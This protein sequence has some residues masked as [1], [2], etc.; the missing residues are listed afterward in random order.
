[1]MPL[2]LISWH[3]WPSVGLGVGV[4]GPSHIHKEDLD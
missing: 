3:C 1:M 4:C 2:K